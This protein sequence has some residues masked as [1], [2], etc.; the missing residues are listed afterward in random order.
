[1]TVPAILQTSKVRADRYLADP[2]A[3]RW[4]KAAILTL[5]GTDPVRAANDAE[6]LYDLCAQRADEAAGIAPK[7]PREPINGVIDHLNR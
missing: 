4:L 6:V 2:A 1:M 7:D 5:T 3:S